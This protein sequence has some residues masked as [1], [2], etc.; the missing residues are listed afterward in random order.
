MDRL[1]RVLRPEELVLPLEVELEVEV[2]LE[3]VLIEKR[4]EWSPLYPLPC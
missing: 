2:G 4:N 3:P 1:G